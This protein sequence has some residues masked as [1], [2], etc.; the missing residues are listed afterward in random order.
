[1]G[2]FPLSPAFVPFAVKRPV[3]SRGQQP[4]GETLGNVD[5]RES[6]PA[7]V[8]VAEFTGDRADQRAALAAAGSA[9]REVEI[10]SVGGRLGSS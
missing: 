9:A 2:R 1:M 4:P 10:N 3:T 8:T 6:N 7:T 5:V